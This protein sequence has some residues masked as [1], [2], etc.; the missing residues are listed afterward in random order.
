MYDVF[1]SHPHTHAGWVEQLAIRLADECK[2]QVW[3]DKW[4][5]V[6]GKNFIPEL[7]RG[8]EEASTCAVCVGKDTPRGWVEQEIQKALNRQ[9]ANDNFR[10]IPLLMPDAVEQSV[11]G[12]LELRT[13]VDFR[14]NHDEA[15]HRLVCGIKG[16]APGRWPPPEQG[17]SLSPLERKLRTIAS[18]RDK[19]LLEPSVVVKVQ[20]DL[21]LEALADA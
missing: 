4:V 14:V 2:F 16:I 19:N 15:F 18:L 6:P 12:F 21:L 1:L 5:L 8:L 11:S 10:V 20:R 7:S 17:A 3:L 9:A 13:W